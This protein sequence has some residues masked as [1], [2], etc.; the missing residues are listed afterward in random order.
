MREKYFAELNAPTAERR[1]EALEKLIKLEGGIPEPIDNV[2]N[3]IHTTYSFSPYSP[4]KAVY[5]ATANRLS[6]AGIMDHDSIAGAEEFIEAAKIAGIASTVGIECRVKMD[7]TAIGM[8]KINNPDQD[9]VAYVALHGVP[10]QNIKMVNDFFAPYRAKRNLRNIKMCQ[11]ITDIMK[12]Y[13]ITLDFERDVLPLSL[14]SEGGSVTERHICMALAQK[15]KKTDINETVK[16][17]VEDMKLPLSAKQIDTLKA[18][19]PE[20]IDYDILGILKGNLVERFYVDADEECPDVTEYIALGKKSGAISAYAYLGDVGDSVTGDKKAQHF[21]DS[22]LDLLADTLYELGFNSVTYMPT[23]N[24]DEQ[25]KRVM[26]FCDEKGF[27]QICGEDINSPR[28]KFICEALNKPQYQH[29]KKAAW[30]LISHE[31]AATK[32]I[33][34]AMFSDETKA[35]KPNISDRI[36]SFYRLIK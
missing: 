27:Y 14:Y 22:Y 19:I 2:N 3:H 16:F 29:L 7:K 21:E 36:D 33:N 20:Y 6:T 23:R 18:N 11:N 25:L 35:K 9:G 17:L 26:K 32:D 24:T 8:R 28:Q 12:P 4:T 30:A 31:R 34:S 15:I 13:G 1:L 10:H 5:M